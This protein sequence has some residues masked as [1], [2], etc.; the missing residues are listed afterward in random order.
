MKCEDEQRLL[1]SCRYVYM[2][3]VHRVL[4]ADE[5]DNAMSHRRVKLVHVSC[6]SIIFYCFI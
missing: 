1:L 5:E 4:C 2:K 3:M 6:H